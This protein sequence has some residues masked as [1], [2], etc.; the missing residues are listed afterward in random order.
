MPLPNLLSPLFAT[1][2][3]VSRSTT[4]WD[5]DARE[6]VRT[7]ARATT[8]IIPAQVSTEKSG[9]EHT[10]TG[11][12]ERADGWLTIRKRDA[13]AR[14]WTPSVGDKITALGHR[15]TELYVEK[16]QD[17]GHWGD[18]SGFSLLRLHFGTRR[19]EAAGPTFL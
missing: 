12:V 6:P 9:N 4:R 11:T 17:I 3:P 10:A 8:V 2:E 1:I 14:S 18:Q 13:D 16:V 15:T 19:P 5:A 7:L